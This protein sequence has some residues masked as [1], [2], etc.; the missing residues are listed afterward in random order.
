ME[1]SQWQSR[2]P[3]TGW[4]VSH[5]PSEP[6]AGP[7]KQG[8]TTAGTHGNLSLGLFEIQGMFLWRN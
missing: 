1:G 6:P 5:P 8:R 4:R 7:L 3:H 2:Y